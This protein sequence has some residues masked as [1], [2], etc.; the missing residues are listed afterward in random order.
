MA[1]CNTKIAT[2][3][4]PLLL[5]LSLIIIIIIALAFPSHSLSVKATLPQK[6]FKTFH[7]KKPSP[8]FLR[9]GEK[10]NLPRRKRSRREKP[11]SRRFSAMLPKG[12]VPPSGSSPCHNV[13]PNSVSFFCDYSNQMQ[14]P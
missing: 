12:Y 11:D 14:K 9:R 7:I 13:Y 10:R 1:N 4:S 2:S 8:P 6:D 3:L 5:L